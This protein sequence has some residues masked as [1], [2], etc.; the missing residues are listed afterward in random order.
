[1]WWGAEISY[2]ASLS[3]FEWS[4]HFSSHTT[5]LSKNDARAFAEIGKDAISDA[6]IFLTA[7]TI[8]L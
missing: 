1:M 8:S 5:W 4:L 2:L 7:L 6:D 3:A